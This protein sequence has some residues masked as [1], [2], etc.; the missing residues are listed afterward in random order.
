MLTLIAL[1]GCEQ[2]AHST[3]GFRLPEGDVDNGKRLFN[4]YG[5]FDCH[6][7]KGTGVNSNENAIAK[8]VDLGGPV[9]LNKT[10]ADILTSI[11]NPSHRINFNLD[12]EVVQEQGESTMRDY[13]EQM[14]VAHL[15]DIVA[16]LQ[17]Q[18]DLI[19]I[20]RTQP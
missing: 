18:Y 12:Q 7:V 13:N 1:T 10:Y 14:T 20:T 16:Y 6:T 5:C 3:R 15:I 4:S 11:V 8:L 17:I 19:P 2:N 9:S